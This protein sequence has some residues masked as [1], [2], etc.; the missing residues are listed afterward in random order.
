MFGFT[1][2]RIALFFADG[3]AFFIGTA[4][5]VV[6][7]LL[8]SRRRGEWRARTVVFIG[9]ALVVVS[10]T[11]LPYLVYGFWLVA[12]LAWVTA[13][14]NSKTPPRTRT[15]LTITAVI[16]SVAAVVGEFPFRRMPQLAAS[17]ADR[18]VVIGDSLS[19]GMGS[20]E[21]TW[22]RVLRAESGLEVIDLSQAGATVSSA[23]TQAARTPPGPAI[24]VLEIG[25]NDLLG[26]T[27]LASFESG[28]ERLLKRVSGP[29]RQLL[30][31]ELPLPP[32][33]NGY[34]RAQRGLARRYGATL[35]PKRVLAGAIGSAGGTLDGLHLSDAGHRRM[36]Q[37]VGG[38]LGLDAGSP[39]NPATR[40]K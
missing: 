24:V 6:G 16:A 35:I 17:R 3:R 40:P 23:I 7:L 2:I 27:T 36:A 5:L 39:R 19:A 38:I 32:F 8:A 28:L 20:G 25:G 18:L 30:M 29:D 21:T 13:E 10:A 37:A 1:M 4:L 9:T 31:F 15:I 33:K 34:G 14:F 11:P 26:Y 12:L 22:P